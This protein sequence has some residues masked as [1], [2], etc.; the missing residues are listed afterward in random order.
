M[1]W[2]RYIKLALLLIVTVAVAPSCMH[3]RGDIGVWFGTW[4][5]TAIEVDGVLDT[6][7]AGNM[8]FKFQTDICEVVT[9]GPHHTYTQSWAHFEER[10][11]GRQIIIDFSYTDAWDS[12][13][14]SPP[15]GSHLID[16][17]NV[18]FN[19]RPGKRDIHLTLN[20]EDGSIVV[21]SLIKE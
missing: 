21:Y 18:L 2:T 1:K 16:G 9:V 6:Q 12:R 5:C 13:N 10:Q 8:F 7:Y 17:E 19:D 14:F 15:V 20:G 4:K 11:D 3:N